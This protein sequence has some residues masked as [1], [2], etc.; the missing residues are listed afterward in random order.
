MPQV[1]EGDFVYRGGR[2]ALIVARFNDTITGRLLEGALDTL[3]RHGVDVE[4]DVE[5]FWVPGAYEMPVAAQK[6]AQTN[7]FSAVVALACV[8]RG[9]T[10]HFDYVAGQAASGLTSVSLSTGLPVSFGVLTTDNIEQALS[11]SGTKM[12]NKG[13]EATIAALEMVNLFRAV[14]AV[15]KE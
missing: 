6:I 5:V 4:K 1:T 14:D 15:E 2:F 10:P 13:H 11:R 7:R 9:G 8:I 3:R 12:G